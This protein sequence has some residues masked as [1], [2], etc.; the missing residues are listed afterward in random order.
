MTDH[1]SSI[2]KPS[3]PKEEGSIW[4]GIGIGI[5]IYL[6]TFFIEMKF[7]LLFFAGPIVHLF[8]IIFFFAKGKKFTGIGLLILAGIMILL[9]SACFGLIIFSLNN[10]G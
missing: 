9:A 5:G 3:E 1:D 4:A 7:A 6:I 2:K 10:G 8:A